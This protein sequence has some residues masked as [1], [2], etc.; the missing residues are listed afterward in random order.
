MDD[1]L[2]LIASTDRSSHRRIAHRIVGWLIGIERS[3]IGIGSAD[4]IDR[5]TD[6]PM[7]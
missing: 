2:S 5:S 7:R 3:L 4:P 1:R 6:P